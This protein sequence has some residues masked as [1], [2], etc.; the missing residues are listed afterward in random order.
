M[1]YQNLFKKSKQENKT[2]QF[3]LNFI[4]T[5]NSNTIIIEITHNNKLQNLHKKG[6]RKEVNYI[7]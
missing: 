4:N 6:I 3:Y 1:N 5:I 2:F 7:K